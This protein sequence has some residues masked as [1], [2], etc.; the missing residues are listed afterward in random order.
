MAASLTT[1]VC[2]V[3]EDKPITG[4]EM[5][6]KLTEFLKKKSTRNGLSDDKFGTLERL[7]EALKQEVDRNDQ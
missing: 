3:Q 7:Q 4:E 5:E 1:T 6:K 2:H